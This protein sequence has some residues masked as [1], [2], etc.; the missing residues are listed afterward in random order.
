MQPIVLVSSKSWH[1]GFAQRLARQVDCPVHF[2][3]NKA[4]LTSE[5]L[6]VLDPR[7]V[8]FLHWSHIIPE[9]IFASF[10]CVIFHMT[11]VP[12]G[13]GGSPLQNL[14]ARGIYSTKLTALRC[15]RGLD[16]GPVYLKRDLSLFGAAEE[17]YLRASELSL[18]MIAE[19]LKSS[20]IPVD[21]QGSPVVFKRRTP[22]EGDLN[23]LTGLRQVFDYI[24]ML[25]AEGYPPAFLETAHFKIEF[26]RAA[27][28]QDCVLADV[29]ITLKKP[30]GN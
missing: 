14:I 25:D 11:D 22:D 15:V 3:A 20:P 8:F 26:G 28:K 19:I 30:D 23:A 6:A 2:I 21:Q 18:E 16:A 24:R 12:F 29:R 17:I 27:L 13:R 4:D 5:R 1:Q 7:Y 9:S 10:E